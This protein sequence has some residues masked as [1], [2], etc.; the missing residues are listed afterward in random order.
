MFLRDAH[1]TIT[2][3]ELRQRAKA[4]RSESS[5]HTST[6]HASV[7]LANAATIATRWLANAPSVL[8]PAPPSSP[9]PPSS[10]SILTSILNP[11][12]SILVQTSGSTGKPKWVAYTHEQVLA[13][14]AASEVNMRPS[15]GASWLLNLPIH[16][17]GGLGILLRSLVWGT[18]VHI[19]DCKG[20]EGI[21]QTITDF[22][23]IDTLSMVPTQLHDILLAGG[24]DRLRRLHNILIGAGSLSEHD[25]ELVNRHKLPVRQSYGMTETIGH[26]CITKRASIAP[27]GFRACGSPLPGN[28]LKVV[29]DDGQPMPE[30][31]IG[32]IWIRGPQVINNYAE[33]DPSKFLDGWFRTGD[34]GYLEGDELIFVARRTDMVKSGGENVIAVRV[35]SALKELPYIE[36]CAVIGIDDQRWGQRVHACISVQAD[37]EISIESLRNDLRNTLL[38]FELPR[39]LSIHESIPRNSMGKLQR[40]LLVVENPDIL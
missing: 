38:P 2:F 29:G 15:V 27:I 23:D 19:S 8:I 37:A 6:I 20:A 9:H 12:S 14:A 33:P 4:L 1:S 7:D 24:A 22:P 16:H 17:A 18:G 39:S 36:D 40:E 35:E 11:Q 10:A 3:D 34:Y 31:H 13:A 32:H 5:I 26:F 28:E 30:G 25:L 21:L